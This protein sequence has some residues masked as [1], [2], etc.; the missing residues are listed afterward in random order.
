MNDYGKLQAHYARTGKPWNYPGK[1][2]KKPT[3]VPEKWTGKD[4]EWNACMHELGVGFDWADDNR[5]CASEAPTPTAFGWA[6]IV[7][8]EGDVFALHLTVDTEE[9]EQDSPWIYPAIRFATPL[10]AA[11]AAMAMFAVLRSIR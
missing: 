11:K 2:E 9:N 6:A 10:E 8:L 5:W 3:R 7:A 4:S 1:A